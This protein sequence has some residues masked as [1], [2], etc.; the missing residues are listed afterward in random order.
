MVVITVTDV[1]EPPAVDGD[2]TATFNED[3]GNIDQPVL[4][5]YTANDPDD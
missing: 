1:G 2:A 4:D 3:T 5:A